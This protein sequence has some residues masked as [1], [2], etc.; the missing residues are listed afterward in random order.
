M[1]PLYIF[2]FNAHPGKGIEPLSPGKPSDSSSANPQMASKSRR[3]PVCGCGDEN[4]ECNKC[5]EGFLQKLTQGE[6][7][8]FKTVQI[9]CR[10]APCCKCQK[11]LAD[12]DAC[13][14]GYM[15]R[16]LAGEVPHFMLVEVKDEKKEG[17]K[18]TTPPKEEVKNESTKTA[19]PG[20]ALGP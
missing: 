11:P 3:I 15:Q 9:E 6:N 10:K 2:M 14:E 20:W 19:N 16:T 5:G 1:N 12:C 7:P 17:A 8:H 18:T 4:P 13:G